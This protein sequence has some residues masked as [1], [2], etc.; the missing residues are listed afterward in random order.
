MSEVFGHKYELY[1]K[2]PTRLIDKHKEVGSCQAP[3]PALVGAR[4]VKNYYD[5]I[6]VTSI[7]GYSVPESD[8][9]TVESSPVLITNPI[10]MTADIEYGNNSNSKGS[11]T[12]TIKLH[13]LSPTTLNNIKKNSAILLK[14]GYD[15]D[16]ELP[17]LFVGTVEKVTTE[18][19]ITEIS[20][21]EGGNVLKTV[22]FQQKFAKG[23]TFLSVFITVMD[24][25][26]QQGIPTGNFYGNA[27]SL[28]ELQEPL[29]LSNTLESVLTELCNMLK[30][31]WFISGGKLYVQPRDEDRVVEVLK[32]YPQNVIGN[33]N[34]NDDSKAVSV[35][36]KDDETSGISFTGFLNPDIRLE[37]YVEV[38]YGDYIGT[39]KPTTIK[40]TL[41]WYNGPWQTKIEAMPVKEYELQR[42]I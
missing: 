18:K 23:T 35:T 34:I 10:Q 30:F 33:I 13:N 37:T 27:D 14:A 1:I 39:Y 16:K 21:K 22:I 32:V 42:T 41:D 28:R 8:Y 17:I 2:L 3:S 12:A 4:N 31:V 38:T 15:T 40:H 24:A 20:C 36:Q 29:N 6:D 25:F 11:Q 26:A 5:F 19:N 9:L 7:T